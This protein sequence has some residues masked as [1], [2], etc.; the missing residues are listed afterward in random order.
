MAYENKYV[1]TVKAADHKIWEKVQPR[2]LAL[3][4]ELTERCNN[5]C[6]HC[7]INLPEHDESARSKELSTDDLKKILKEAASLGCLEVRLTGGEPLLRPD[8]AELYTFIRRLGIKVLL[9][10]NATLIDE[11]F[12][13]LFKKYPP[14]Q[15]IEVTVY[16]MTKRSYEA[17]SRVKGSYKK[18]FRG[19]NLLL[20]NEIPFVVKSAILPQNKE[21]IPAFEAWARTIPWM[22]GSPQYSMFFELR[23][24]QD[25]GQK[26]GLIAK[27]RATPDEGIKFLTRDPEA[28]RQDMQNFIAKIAPPPG[29][30]LF[31]CGAGQKGGT[32]DAYGQFQVCML[33]R[34]PDTLYDLKSGTLLDALDNFFPKVLAAKVTNSEYLQKCAKCFLKDLCEQCPGKAWTEHGTLDTPVSYL[35]EITHKQARYLGILGEDEWSWQVENWQKRIKEFTSQKDATDEP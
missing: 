32:I 9:F 15:L 6:M 35:C 5:N 22:T 28:F 11:T 2:L 33:V 34:H 29:D 3:D 7:C 16:G 24:R 18:A 31:I 27:V 20:E 14:G 13:R 26:N 4:I 17:V 25:S 23:N 10:T 8:F 21:D 19:I 30:K 1:K 12:V